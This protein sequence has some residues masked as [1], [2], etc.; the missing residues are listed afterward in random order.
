MNWVTSD[1]G[2][3]TTNLVCLYITESHRHADLSEGIEHIRISSFNYLQC[4]I[5]NCVFSST[6][7]CDNAANMCNLSYNHQIRVKF[8]AFMHTPDKTSYV[9]LCRSCKEPLLSYKVSGCKGGWVRSLN[10]TNCL[11]ELMI[12]AKYEEAQLAC[13]TA[14]QR[15]QL[16][17]MYRPEIYE[18]LL[19][20]N[21]SGPGN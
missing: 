17:M 6:I 12:N 18:M 10:S 4:N 1:V 5:W 11:K 13:R 14:A 9:C 20:M 19:N 3:P 7:F 2:G 16:T 15:S 21:I 8:D